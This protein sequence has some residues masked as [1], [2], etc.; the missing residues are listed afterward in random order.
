MTGKEKPKLVR[1]A[2]VQSSTTSEASEDAS[3]AAT[4]VESGGQA[5]D[6]AVLLGCTADV[7]EPT[8]VAHW[9]PE[10]AKRKILLVEDNLV[11]SKLG[12]RMLVTLGYEVILAY[13]G[14]EAFE[15]VKS[16]HDT[17]HVVL[18]DLQVR[19]RRSYH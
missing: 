2:S 6:K 11:N 18:M 13:N 19:A 3:T 10:P 16:W 7:L 9:V 17:I 1:F 5:E 8:A 12:Q 15:T 4:S 14:L